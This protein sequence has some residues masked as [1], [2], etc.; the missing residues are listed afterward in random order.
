VVTRIGGPGS[1][2]DHDPDAW[3]KAVVE[4]CVP[5]LKDLPEYLRVDA[6]S[7]LYTESRVH[8]DPDTPWTVIFGDD[9]PQWVAAKLLSTCLTPDKL[10]P[11]YNPDLRP[12]IEA[13]TSTFRDK[14]IERGPTSKMT[15]W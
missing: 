3:P 13:I 6:A 1:F 8:S 5:I 11:S 9:A 4:M 2:P 15:H 7:A 10:T 12:T 14:D